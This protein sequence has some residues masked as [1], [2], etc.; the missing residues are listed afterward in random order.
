M[1][2]TEFQFDREAIKR[3]VKERKE[4][5]LKN[6]GIRDFK[7]YAVRMMTE[8]LESDPRRYR[9]FGPYWPAVKEALR[10]CGA[11]VKGGPVFPEVAKA[12]RGDTHEETFVMAEQFSRFYLQTHF[13]YA[14]NF[15]LDAEDDEEWFCYDPD[16]EPIGDGE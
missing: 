15:L 3:T 8:L 13:L 16:Y 12:Y 5:L 9:D 4:T 2:Y 6:T 14:N 7:G 1:S 11:A 10:E